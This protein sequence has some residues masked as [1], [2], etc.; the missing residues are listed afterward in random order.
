MRF[1]FVESK[2]GKVGG[3]NLAE[4]SVSGGGGE[5]FPFRLDWVAV[6]SRSVSH[7][8]VRR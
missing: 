1:R 4:K 3:G 5:N 7:L 8:V 2:D 6:L